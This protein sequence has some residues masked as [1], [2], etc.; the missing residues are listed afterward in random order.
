MGGD[1]LKEVAGKE[2]YS[3]E[4]KKASELVA[5]LI[6]EPLNNILDQAIK[7]E[8]KQGKEFNQ[9]L[10]A[11]V[12]VASAAHLKNLNEAKKLALKDNRAAIKHK[13]FIDAAKAKGTLHPAVPAQAV[14]FDET[15]KTIRTTLYSNGI[16]PPKWEVEQKNLREALIKLSQDDSSGKIVMSVDHV[17]KIIQKIN[18]KATDGNVILLDKEQEEL[19]KNFKNGDGLNLRDLIRKEWEAPLAQQKKEALAPFAKELMK[20]MFPNQKKDL[21]FAADLINPVW[22]FT[23]QEPS[24]PSFLNFR[25]II[26]A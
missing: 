12:L 9:K 8:E 25:G 7:F 15:I 1:I 6:V 19:F 5:N 26:K 3:D 18:E 16:L 24:R 22:D 20:V 10:M 14:T 21:S 13:D 11:K 23:E 2:K 17:I 4:K